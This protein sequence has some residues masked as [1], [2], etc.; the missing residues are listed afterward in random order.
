M[1]DSHL[2][3]V[4]QIAVG[5]IE[6][7]LIGSKAGLDRKLVMLSALVHKLAGQLSLSCIRHNPTANIKS[8]H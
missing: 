1:E 8:R 7:S 3:A 5:A 2:P 4:E 6:G